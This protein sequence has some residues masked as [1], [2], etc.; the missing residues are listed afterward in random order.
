M[1]RLALAL[2]VVLLPLAAEAQEVLLRHALGGKALDALATLTLRFNDAQKGR[3]KVVLQGVDGVADRQQLPHLALLHDDDA[4]AFFDTRP[5]FVH[6]AD[7]MKQEKQPFDAGRFYPQVADSVADLLGR[8]QALPLALALPVLFYNKAAFAR[9]GLDPEL[10]PVTW[11]DVQQTAGKLFDSGYRCPLTSSRFAWVHLEN[12]ATQHAEPA[13]LRGPRGDRYTF[14]NLVEVKHIALLA[15]WHKSSYFRYFG[16]G[17]EADAQ[18]VSGECA[19][20]TGESSLVGQLPED[21][22]FSVGIADLP[23]YEDVYG[24]RRSNVIPDGATLRALPGKKKDEYRLAARF[25]A[26]LMR[27]DSQ[28]EWVRATGFLPMS[29]AAADGAG[30]A[31]AVRRRLSQPRQAYPRTRLDFGR[32]RVREILHEE[33]DLVWKDVKPAKQAL[34]DAMRRAN[35]VQ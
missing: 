30:V 9:A 35:A 14:N 27:P 3:G 34:D 25:V 22:A 21:L 11:W 26:F 7:I 33:I 29:A 1:P 4:W 5:R 15:S 6:M 18:F 12:L 8:P 19:M 28:R 10:P 13:L 24:A 32:Q 23:Y 2:L 16:P 17:H 20:L 31:D